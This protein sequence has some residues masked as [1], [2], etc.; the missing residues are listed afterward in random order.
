MGA[1]KSS[2]A[3]HA[4]PSKCCS[5]STAACRA[6]SAPAQWNRCSTPYPASIRCRRLETYNLLEMV[7]L[8]EIF[9]PEFLRKID[10]EQPRRSLREIYARANADHP[11]DRMLYLDWKITL[12]DND[13]R[14]VGRMA[15][16]AGVEVRYPML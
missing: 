3:M 11:V 15:E 16:V 7:P 10:P 13:L 6:G 12:A 9:E 1:M 2:P 5:N 14:K 8:P 4:M